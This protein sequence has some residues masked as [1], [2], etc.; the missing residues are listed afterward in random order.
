MSAKSYF[1][2]HKRVIELK[3]KLGHGEGRTVWMTVEAEFLLETGKVRHVSY[4]AFRWAHHNF[5][6]EQNNRK[7]LTK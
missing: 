4:G 6:R 3:K 2:Y 5:I 7:N 1:Q